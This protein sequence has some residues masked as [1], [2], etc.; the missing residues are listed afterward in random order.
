M[1][2]LNRFILDSWTQN[3]Y[4]NL[5]LFV[6]GQVDLKYRE[7]HSSLVPNKSP[8]FFLGVRMPILRKIAKAISKGNGRNFLKFPKMNYYEETI[9]YGLV[10]CSIEPENYE[11]FCNLF[12][13]FIPMI[14]N[15][16]SCDL[17]SG[18]SKYF[19]KY[20][21]D[22]FSYIEKYISS[23]NPWAVRYAILTMFQYKKDVEYLEEI[24]ER[25]CAMNLDY[26]YVKMAKAWL[27]AELFVYHFDRMYIF[28]KTNNYDRETLTMTFGKIRDS[29]RISDENKVKIQALKNHLDK[30][31]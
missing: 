22:Y 28:L 26:Y 6:K 9:L 20:K 23:S 24:L 17:I 25:L 8:D 31:K 1:E 3:D 29:Y 7:F 5:L 27:T 30:S 10:I 14:D 19:K 13:N 18:K 2:N 16:A 21:K 4:D 12:D 15:W 11:D